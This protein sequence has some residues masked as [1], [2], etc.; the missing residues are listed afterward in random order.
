M[1]DIIL[2]KT[3]Y[4]IWREC[5]KNA[6]YKIHQPEIYNSGELSDF[7]KQIIETGNEV[8]LVARQLFAQGLLV[9]GRGKEAEEKTKELLKTGAHVIFQPVF[10]KN[11]FLAAVDVLELRQ[12]GTYNIYEIKSTSDIDKKTHYHDVAFQVN[13][14]EQCGLKIS[15]AFLIHLNS[16]YIRKGDLNIFQLFVTEDVTEKALQMQQE[17]GQE[18]QVALNY[19][20][21]ENEPLGYCD[22]VYKGRSN[23]CTTFKYS[24]EKVPA[25]GVHDITRI[26]LSKGKLQ[27]MVDVGI[28]ELSDVPE[29]IFDTLTPAQQN[30]IE[31]HLTGR[32]ILDSLSIKKELSSLVFPLYFLDYETFP[33]A[34]P[35]FDGF[36]PYMF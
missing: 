30:Q 18:M 26:G 6:W 19:I 27:N 33:S 23:H 20:L 24:N 14:L 35:R 36:S 2:S 12:D 8:E 7:E 34:L 11:H 4:L 31:T 3:D 21:Q 17:V 16:E 28:F 25:Y 9:E 32:R 1:K 29:D 22:C 10:V 13:L 15:G 5:H